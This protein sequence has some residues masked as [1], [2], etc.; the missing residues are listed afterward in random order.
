MTH[1]IDSNYLNFIKQQFDN[2]GYYLKDT[3][4]FL[5]N[6]SNVKHDDLTQELDLI[7]KLQ[8]TYWKN[9]KIELDDEEI[10]LDSCHCIFRLQLNEDFTFHQFYGNKQ[11]QCSTQEMEQEKEIS[12]DDERAFFEQYYNKIQRHY[13]SFQQG[14]W[15]I[16]N[17]ELKLVNVQKREVLAFEIEKLNNETL[18]LKLVE[19]NYRIEMK[20][21]S[22]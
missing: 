22:R 4:I 7:N 13:L 11:S 5:I 17:N 15:Q 8:N 1:P 2:S 14:N 9:D 21:V 6:K 16:E 20:R 12:I 3:T 18:H 19:T 10:E